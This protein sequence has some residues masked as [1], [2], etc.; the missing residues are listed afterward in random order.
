MFSRITSEEVPLFYE[1]IFDEKAMS[2]AFS[3]CPEAS[4]YFLEMLEQTNCTIE[5]FESELKFSPFVFPKKNRWGFG[6]MFKLNNAKSIED[7]WT[8]WECR[9]PRNPAPNKLKE[10]S[11]S[12]YQ[13]VDIMQLFD[14]DKNERAGTGRIQLMTIDGIMVDAGN[15][16]N[17]GAFDFSFARPVLEFCKKIWGKDRKIYNEII[18]AMEKI[19]MHLMGEKKMKDYN[20][21]SFRVGTCQGD[22]RLISLSCPGNCA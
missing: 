20:K 12:I 5:Y 21:H 7:G 6:G 14:Y 2:I 3:L 19:W 16:L 1:T 22:E 11:G 10:I 13:F 15:Y 17:Q 8:T 9:L 18:G 4:N